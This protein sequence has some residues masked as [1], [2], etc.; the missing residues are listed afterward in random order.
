MVSAVIA[1]VSASAAVL[2]L[3]G[4]T[5]AR[6]TAEGAARVAEAAATVAKE[7][8]DRTQRARPTVEN[9]AESSGG[10]RYSVTLSNTGYGSARHVVVQ[11][12]DASGREVGRSG[13]AAIGDFGPALH[14]QQHRTL[15]AR[16]HERTA[17][18]P[19]PDYP[20]TVWVEWKHWERDD[21]ERHES[22][23]R[24]PAPSS[25]AAP[26]AGPAVTPVLSGTRHELALAE[27]DPDLVARYLGD[28]DPDLFGPQSQRPTWAE[29]KEW[30]EESG[31]LGE[32][33]DASHWQRVPRG[34]KIR[35]VSVDDRAIRW[36]T[37]EAAKQLGHTDRRG[38]PVLYHDDL[39]RKDD[40]DRLLRKG[41]VEITDEDRMLV[42][43]L[44]RA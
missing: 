1:A 3:I 28:P 34:E 38:I 23:W 17:D 5:R 31:M 33:T 6:R 10:K 18:A 30:F 42:T 16:L 29:L 44:K 37:N 4:S 13:D 7:A 9:V 19:E 12:L 32:V 27:A 25:Q 11:L 2:G 26:I 21:I 8:E 24:T 20:L 36:A 35:V 15:Q 14:P 43:G 39:C 40:Q 41:Y 22:S